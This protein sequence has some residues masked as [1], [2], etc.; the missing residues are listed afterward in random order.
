MKLTKEQVAAYV[1]GGG[2]SCP[3]CDGAI[4]YG[5][6]VE[7]ECGVA[8]QE[9]TCGDCGERWTDVYWLHHIFQMED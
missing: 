4:A 2:L 1:D 6:A 7:V 3:F 8:F 5:G 9:M